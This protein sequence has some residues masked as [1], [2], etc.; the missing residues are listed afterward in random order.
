MNPEK[1]KSV[2]IPLDTYKTLKAMAESEPRPLSG[3]FTFLIE[4]AVAVSQT[5]KGD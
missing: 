2:V 3:Q 5:E 4:K 1:W